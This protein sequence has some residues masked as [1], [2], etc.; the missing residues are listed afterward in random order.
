MS[1][2]V[3]FGSPELAVPPLRAL[4]DAG[5]EIALVVSK[6]DA[7]RGRGGSTTPS[8]VK[9]AARDAGIPTTEDPEEALHVGAEFGVVV[10]YGR[11]LSP[12]LVAGLPMVN[13]HFSLLPRWRGAAPVERAILEGDHETG[14]CLM[15]IEEGLDTGGVYRTSAV[16]IRH[17]TLEELQRELVDL[18]CA[19]LRE[20]LADGLTSLGPAAPQVGEATYAKKVKPTEYE[21][22]LSKPASELLRTIRLGRAWVHDGTKRLRILSATLQP[23]GLAPGQVEGNFVGTGADV[24]ELGEVQPEGR[25]R[26][27]AASWSRG[28]RSNRPL[29]ASLEQDSL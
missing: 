6:P 24:L 10:A 17:K 21:L 5:H 12:Q 18:G 8:P 2:L 19:Q 15:A 16:T 7:R 26:M 22:D 29:G 1:R 27:D 13:L 3:Y 25:G 4:L 9:A 11:L 14:V 28:R 20:A 23:G